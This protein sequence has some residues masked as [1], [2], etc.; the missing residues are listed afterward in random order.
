MHKIRFFP[1]KS[2][3]TLGFTSKLSLGQVTPNT[4]IF[5]FIWTYDKK[6]ATNLPSLNFPVGSG[7]ADIFLACLKVKMK[8]IFEIIIVKIFLPFIF[9]ICFV[10][11]HPQHMQICF[12]WEI[13]KNFQLLTLTLYQGTRACPFIEWKK[14]LTYREEC[15]YQRS[16]I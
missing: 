16:N 5:S 15:E 14:A 1:E 2:E 10:N 12:G 11:E 3:E 6:I 13:K 9:N 7:K 8:K 4:S